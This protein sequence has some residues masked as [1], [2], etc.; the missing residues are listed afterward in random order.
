MEKEIRTPNVTLQLKLEGARH[1]PSGEVP[2]TEVEKTAIE[3]EIHDTESRVFRHIGD[4]WTI[5][6][7]DDTFRIAPEIDF[8]AWQDCDIDT[9]LMRDGKSIIICIENA[10][11]ERSYGD[12]PPTRL[13]AGEEIVATKVVYLDEGIFI[14]RLHISWP[15]ELQKSYS[16]DDVSDKLLQYESQF[17]SLDKDKYVVKVLVANGPYQP[18]VIGEYPV[19]RFPQELTEL[20]NNNPE[21]F[22][23]ATLIKVNTYYLNRTYVERSDD[24]QDAAR[25]HGEDPTGFYRTELEKIERL[26]LYFNLG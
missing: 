6:V 9:R 12:C 2:L 1:T 17:Q 8:R 21:Q 15:T 7:D 16:L 19:S 23:D 5:D 18:E 14:L 11:P 13:C 26:S 4:E 10:T 20:I 3:K 24:Y 22:A 25:A